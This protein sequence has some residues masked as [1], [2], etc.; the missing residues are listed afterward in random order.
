MSN[1]A[2]FRPSAAV[3]WV[4]IVLLFLVGYIH[5]ALFTA[6]FRFGGPL[7][8]LL[9]LNAFGAFAAMYGVWRRAHWWGWLLGLVVAGGA[10]IARLV[11]DFVPG[12]RGQLLGRPTGARH[13][14]NV[15]GPA[16]TFRFHRGIGGPP[17][18]HGHGM[19]GLLPL[20][21]NMGTLATVSI[22]IEVAFVGL[23]IYVLRSVRK[24]AKPGHT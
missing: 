1:V 21:G 18:V 22:S 8:A 20:L 4:G 16:G 3:V 24:G 9:A 13:F 19:H 2:A 23:A 14:G 5:L 7:A 17:F 10:A 11:M 12:V 6:M 15:G